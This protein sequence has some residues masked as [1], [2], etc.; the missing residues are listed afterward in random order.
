[1]TCK[2]N[3]EKNKPGT[4]ILLLRLHEPKALIVLFS[5][6]TSMLYLQNFPYAVCSE[7]RIDMVPDA[8]GKDHESFAISN[9]LSLWVGRKSPHAGR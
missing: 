6:S 9:H 4:Q 5:Y 2:R 1:M 7:K 8:P 3:T